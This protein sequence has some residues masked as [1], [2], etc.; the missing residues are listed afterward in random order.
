MLFNI[1]SLFRTLLTCIELLY[2]IMYHTDPSDGAALHYMLRLEIY[3]A[4][5]IHIELL[6]IFLILE[7]LKPGTHLSTH[8]FA[9]HQMVRCG[10]GYYG[11]CVR[12]RH[13]RN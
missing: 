5:A 4:T 7:F 6:Q 3:G 11:K 13:V 2:T 10:S 12:M 9:L 8:R 1:K